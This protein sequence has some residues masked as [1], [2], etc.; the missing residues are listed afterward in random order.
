MLELVSSPVRV[1]E[2]RQYT[3]R[4]SGQPM[5]RRD[6]TPVEAVRYRVPGEDRDRE[7]PLSGSVNGDRVPEGTDCRLVIEQYLKATTR[8]GLS[9]TWDAVK[10]RVAGFAKS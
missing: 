8:E 3:D 9:F 10:Y 4:R 5:T 2:F 1:T 6:G 7:L